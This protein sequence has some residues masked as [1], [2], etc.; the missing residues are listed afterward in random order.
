M[1]KKKRNCSVK[2]MK[3][4]GCHCFNENVIQCNMFICIQPMTKVQ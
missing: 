3:Q 2:N 1:K 4:E